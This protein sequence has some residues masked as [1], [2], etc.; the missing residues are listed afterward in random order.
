[1]AD[2]QK[3]VVVSRERRQIRSRESRVTL[4]AW[5]VEL[6][7]PGGARGAITYADPFFRGEGALLGVPQ[8]RLAELWKASLADLPEEQ[9]PPQLG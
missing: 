6:D 9:P 1:M 5:R 2:R 3:V 8:D 7:L 4:A